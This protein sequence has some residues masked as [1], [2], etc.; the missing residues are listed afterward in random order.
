MMEELFKE[1]KY[2]ADKE[3]ISDDE[4]FNANESGGGNFDDTFRLGMRDGE[5]EFA[6]YLLAKYK[7]D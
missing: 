2:L 6:R 3:A 4:N 1:L 5:I 7:K